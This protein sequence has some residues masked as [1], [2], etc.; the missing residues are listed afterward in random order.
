[1]SI[2]SALARAYD[3]LPEAPAPGFSAE[4]ISFVIS[5]NTDGSVA[6]VVDIRDGSGKKRT[7]KMLEVPQGVK[8]ASGIASNFLWDKTAYVLGITA[9]E[10]K[11]TAQE[12]AAFVERH[13][14]ALDGTEDAGLRAL[15]LFLKSWNPE[16]FAPP[17]WPEEMRDQ[18]VV[19]A[20]ESE[21]LSGYL[22][23]RPA[24]RDIWIKLGAES[25][26]Q[27]VQCLVS[28]AQ[29]PLARLH[30][31]IKGVWGAQTAGASIVSFNLDAFTSYGHEQGE[32]AP[33]SEASAFKYTTALNVFLA[34]GSGHRLQIGDA[35]TVFWAEAP[36]P[37]LA[38]L[39]E[40]YFGVIMNGLEP[41]S[42]DM[43]EQ[44]AEIADAERA[45]AEEQAATRVGDKLKQMKQGI[46][47]VEI[48]PELAEG[49]RFYVLALSPN[50]A[51]LSVRLWL[52]SDFGVLAE[53]YRRYL[54]DMRLE[55]M[56]D[57]V[58]GAP[59]WR[60]LIEV[61]VLGKRENAPPHLAG[62]WLRAMLTGA[63]YPHSLLATVLMRLR[64]DRRVSPLRVAILKAILI[65]NCKM[66]VP[67][68][69]DPENTN[70]GYMLGRLFAVYEEVQRAALGNNVNA[71]VKDK[72]YGSASAQPRSVFAA[73][74]RGSA[75]H[76]SKVGKTSPG[77][78]VNLEKKITEIMAL[79][80]PEK[81]PFPASLPVEDQALF[82]LGYYHQRATFFTPSAKTVADEG[83]DQ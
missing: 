32:N 22:H 18:N 34:K 68:T 46:P 19:F 2:L 69:L 5:L 73:L 67:V 37:A 16:Q 26:G 59:F 70:K 40:H 9:G 8:R 54:E 57:A 60:L 30:P 63:A 50:A 38:R 65:R 14:T 24:A 44:L 45:T 82:G 20:L 4:K 7:P 52:E 10:G 61:A 58:V 75:N 71:T 53:N 83:H 12:H 27:Q 55:P 78:R 23:D 35:S 17:F 80:A 79:M 3:H 48:A 15:C 66:E 77:R 33:V 81:D 47:L 43:E 25:A 41:L 13:L 64:A 49:V 62:E 28:G 36:E 6:Q 21:R 51:R 76:L 42:P 1:M 56:P 11:R 31:S 39:A 74:D 72:F 29:G